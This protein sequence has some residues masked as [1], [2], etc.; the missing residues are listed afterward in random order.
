MS[1]G[2][3]LGQTFGPSRSREG[4][5]ALPFFETLCNE[6]PPSPPT[7]DRPGALPEVRHQH[8]AARGIVY[9]SSHLHYCLFGFLPF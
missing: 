9:S 5:E 6:S 4:A 8:W 2:F 1:F 3:V 7:P